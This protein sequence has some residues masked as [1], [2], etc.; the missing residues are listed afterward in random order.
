MKIGVLL[1]ARAIRQRL[2]S[3][4]DELRGD[5]LFPGLRP[6]VLAEGA[7]PL[8]R[9]LLP[10]L[11]ELPAPVVIR[12]ASYG[13]ARAPQGEPRLLSPLPEDAFEGYAAL[14]LDDVLDTGN[15]LLFLRA[16]L[17]DAGVAAVRV[18][19][20]LEKKAPRPRAVRPD[21]TGFVIGD[22]FVVGY[23]MDLA[24]R[25]RELP[26]VGIVAK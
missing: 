25:Y 9:D 10:L 1:T 11:P 22:D 7:L 16:R 21:Y 5:A 13:D 15:T 3:L 17:R 4:A 14:L 20:L 18:C 24:G 19:V 2:R 23:G 6:V 12:V 8:A 26:Y